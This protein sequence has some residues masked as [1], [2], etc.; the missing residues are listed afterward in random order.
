MLLT[1]KD[2]QLRLTAKG[3]LVGI[4]GTF[5]T[6]LLFVRFGIFE[7]ARPTL[8][9]MLV[10]VCAVA[11]KWELRGRVWFWAAVVILAILHLILIL[12]VPWTARWIPAFVITPFLILDFGAMLAIIALLKRLFEKA[13]PKEVSHSPNAKN[14]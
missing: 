9:S 3:I 10:I 4:G 13:E 6:G 7:L 8:L 14:P 12:C 2:G 11:M 1:K 5:V